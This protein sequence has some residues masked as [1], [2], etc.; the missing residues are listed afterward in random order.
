[1]KKIN[2]ELIFKIIVL[3]QLTIILLLLLFP[4]NDSEEINDSNEN[5]RYKEVK[6]KRA[7]SYGKD[8]GEEVR[9]LDT[10][11]GEFVEP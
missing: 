9:I 5:G 4:S 10:Q 2:F 8:M 7:S 3:I 6:T 1:M 11:T